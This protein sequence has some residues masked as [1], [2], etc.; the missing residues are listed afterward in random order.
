[1]VL[2]FSFCCAP[3]FDDGEA[4]GRDNPLF[5]TLN[6]TT[7]KS[8]RTGRKFRLLCA[9]YHFRPVIPGRWRDVTSSLYP[10]FLF[11]LGCVGRQSLPSHSVHI[12]HL[13]CES[14]N[15]DCF[16]W[17]WHSIC[18]KLELSQNQAAIAR[19]KETKTSQSYRLTCERNQQ[20]SYQEM[21]ATSKHF[22]TKLVKYCLHFLC[23]HRRQRKWVAYLEWE[24]EKKK[25]MSE[26]KLFPIYVAFA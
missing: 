5:S 25:L 24:R 23:R 15:W 21:V 6:E 7:S 11:K 16:W 22:L 13:G 3:P 18:A 10:R 9:A 8:C 2:Q 26:G 20:A 1:M 19:G 14:Y 4:C 12:L 17:F